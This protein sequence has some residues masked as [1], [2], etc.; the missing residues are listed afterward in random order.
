MALVHQVLR[1]IRV[2]MMVEVEVVDFCHYLEIFLVFDDDR[3]IHGHRT[4]I[5]TIKR[6]RTIPIISPTSPTLIINQ[7]TIREQLIRVKFND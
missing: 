5:P 4:T 2:N 7:H 6:H 1:L 3:S